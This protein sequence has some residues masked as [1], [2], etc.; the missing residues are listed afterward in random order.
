MPPLH[1]NPTQLESAPAARQHSFLKERLA[2]T[3]DEVAA[4][5][6]GATSHT[7][8]AVDQPG[9]SSRPDQPQI[10]PAEHTSTTLD[11]PAEAETNLAELRRH[12]LTEFRLRQREQATF[13]E[14]TPGATAGSLAIPAL[15]ASRRGL[16]VSDYLETNRW[17]LLG[18]TVVREG[19]SGK[20]PAMS[21]RVRGIA[22]APG[23]QRIYVASANGGIWRS[24]DQG[25]T[26]LSL[27]EAFDLNPSHYRADSLACG[28]VALAPGEWAGQDMIFV[29]SGEP[30]VVP[31]FQGDSAYFGVGPIVSTDGGLNWTTEPS[32]PSLAGRAFYALA[33]DPHWPQRVVAATIDGL[34]C[35]EIDEHGN[36]HWVNKRNGHFCSVVATHRNNVTTFYAAAWYGGIWQ[37]HDGSTWHSLGNGFPG[38]G[39]SGGDSRA[40]AN[41]ARN[42]NINVGRIGLAVQDDN[43]DILYALVANSNGHLHGLYRMDRAESTTARNAEE[44]AEEWRPVRNV[45]STLFGPDLQQPGQGGY[46]LA[47]AIDPDDVN[48]VYI[49]GSIVLSDGIQPVRVGGDWSGALYRC[50]IEVHPTRRTVRAE[51]T[52]IGGAIHGDLH[53]LQFAPGD[54]DQLWVGCDGGVFFC[55]VP[56]ADPLASTQEAGLFQPRNT[57]LATLTMNYLAQH[58]TEEAVLF[59][60]TQDNGGL[61]HT[62][63]PVWLYSSGGDSGYFV[64]NW[65][66]PYRVLTTYTY[67]MIFRTNDGG[68]RYSYEAVHVLP[69]NGEAVQFYAPLAGTPY[70]P[71]NPASAERVAFGGERVWLSDHFGGDGLRWSGNG[72]VGEVDWRSLPSNEFEEDRLDGN[73]EALVFASDR[74]LYA[75]TTS[76]SI[77]QFEE[78][79]DE[80]ESESEGIIQPLST[81]DDAE[82]HRT[83][84]PPL[85]NTVVAAL[86]GSITAIAVDPAVASGDAIYVTLGGIANPHRVWYFDGVAWEPRSGPQPH[87]PNEEPGLLDVQHNAIVVDPQRPEHLYVAADIG[88]WRSVDRGKSW[89]VFSRGLPDAAVVDLKLHHSGRLLRAATH[90]RGV[91]EFDLGRPQRPVDL[92]IRDHLLDLGR[93]PAV[94]GHPDPTEPGALVYIGQSPDIKLDVLGENGAYHVK[95]KRNLQTDPPPTAM[96]LY[97]FTAQ[98]PETTTVPTHSY[99]NLQ[100]HV[101]VQ[102]HNRGL[103]TANNV[104]VMLLLMTQK[105]QTASTEGEELLPLPP[106]PSGYEAFVRRG[107]PIAADEWQT[108]GMATL[109][110][111]RAGNPRIAHFVLDAERLPTPGRLRDDHTFALVA[112]IHCADDPFIAEAER[113]L[114]PG[115]NR[116]VAHRVIS[117]APFD[118]TVPKGTPRRTSG[119]LGTDELLAT[120]TV[121]RGETLS[122]IA[123]QY[124]HSARRWP[125]LYHANRQLIGPDP[126]YLQKGWILN[127]PHL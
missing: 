103:L 121:Q 67:N 60:G 41:S 84:L 14:G 8:D 47:L 42:V 73:T 82:W 126:N 39:V 89:Q 17:N 100:S 81:R 19:Q 108:I 54:G 70:D 86:P 13:S 79:F 48:R 34:Y 110:G 7:P 38:S 116:H 92:Y 106:L 85:A 88:V 3:T 55:D 50:E 97:T 59:C 124:Y 31:W 53:T 21:G 58:P 2:G 1:N 52:Y 5:S 80:A 11:T 99:S 61:R 95:E 25:Q 64:V 122:H 26:W 127:I 35:R 77:Y 104:R 9:D 119:A 23:G 93:Y 117:V 37:S 51:P 94:S 63:D 102:I 49:G 45:P 22:V 113:I 43:P 105:G 109:H 98:L 36:Y 28:A 6:R 18:P 72:W 112:L 33:V 87:S 69:A 96:D 24:E 101:Y 71:E 16:E 32:E 78:R 114:T 74:K 68:R 66:D 57:G 44:Q 65:H 83:Q 4:L 118:G 27:M 12:R 111:I 46:D 125:L 62:G 120:H 90:G 29:G 20:Q 91:Y 15:A 107:L 10:P 76:G 40:Q 115:N 30:G 123:K 56:T 75:G